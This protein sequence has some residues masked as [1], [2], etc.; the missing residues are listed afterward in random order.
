MPVMRNSDLNELYAEP[1]CG[2]IFYQDFTGDVFYMPADKWFLV[3]RG[4]I[5]SERYTPSKIVEISS[6]DSMPNLECDP[7]FS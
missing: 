6:P 2:L 3:G 5:I 1:V 7:G 4:G